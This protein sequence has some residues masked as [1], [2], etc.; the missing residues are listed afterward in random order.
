MMP[1]SLEG[2]HY[3]F[4]KQILPENWGNMFIQ[5]AVPIYHATGMSQSRKEQYGIYKLTASFYSYNVWNK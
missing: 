4:G 2:W 1:C 5:K 3:H